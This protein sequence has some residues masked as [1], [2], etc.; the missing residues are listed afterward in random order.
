MVYLISFVIW[1]L[2]FDALRRQFSWQCMRSVFKIFII[3]AFIS[4]TTFFFQFEASSA[5]H[6]MVSPQADTVHILAL[7][8]KSYQQS[9][10][11]SVIHYAQKAQ[12]LSRLISYDKGM[13]R[14]LWLMGMAKYYQG[15][16]DS[17]SY[18]LE[19]GLPYANRSNDY[20]SLGRI[21]NSNANIANYLGNQAYAVELYFKALQYKEQIGDPTDQAIT[22]NN[23]ANVFFQQG[24]YQK[25]REYYAKS[26][27][28]RK[29]AGR[30]HS[31]LMLHSDMAHNFIKLKMYD[32]A[33]FYIESAKPYVE[34]SRDNFGIADIYYAKVIYYQA[35]GRKDSVTY[36]A[37]LGLDKAVQS[38]SLD[39]ETVFRLLLADHYNK[40]GDFQ[41]GYSFADEACKL[42]KKL[43]RINYLKEATLQRSIGLSGQGKSAE[44]LRLFKHYKVLSDCT[45]N[46]QIKNAALAKDYQYKLQKSQME[47]ESKRLAL[48]MELERE[49][50]LKYLA[51]IIVI[52]LSL[53]VFIYY[54]NYRLKKKTNEKLVKSQFEIIEKNKE[55]EFQNQ[56][57]N[58]Q[59]K[60]IE[61]INES[62]EETIARRTREIQESVKALTQ[63]NA[64]LEQFSYIIS[65]NLRAPVARIKGLTHLVHQS[66]D[67]RELEQIT[68][69]IK[70]ASVDLENVVADLT[71]IINIRTK[72]LEN[73][74]KIEV[75]KIMDT[76]LQFLKDDLEN[77]K[78]NVTL[79][80]RGVPEILTVQPY[81]RSIV[82]NLL[83]NA[84]K[85][86]DTRRDLNIMVTKLQDNGYHKFSISDNG[87]GIDLTGNNLNKI[88]G[89]YQRFHTNIEGRGL[90]LYLV[91]TQ[92][93]MLGGKITTESEVGKGTT[94][95]FYIPA[96]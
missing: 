75:S 43:G 87:Q 20:Q 55:I 80:I 9:N 73:R 32:S 64:N 85:Y 77:A 50:Q 16:L 86:R 57:L 68:T 92:L 8:E 70:E 69:M 23:I 53:L 60:E 91:K 30:L 5:P 42:S 88:F 71:N 83:T 33:W 25:A 39:R 10:M 12:S 46:N 22:L 34:E 72:P 65:H 28:L 38:G 90:G 47:E 48:L 2:L 45:T 61:S 58:Q 94:F 93:E 59:K 3:P 44:A 76:I 51:L 4:F 26:Y 29:Q 54:R 96:N 74:E 11:D 82:T 21:Y 41:Q 14:A 95:T 81:F 35:L 18:F 19:S 78:A 66:M 49:Q 79:D 62:L 67:E 40:E 37:L 52:V 24:D 31:A 27:A 13:A 1:R 63:Q 89:L 56:R 7:C 84:I 17:S 15:Q 6:L 36:Y